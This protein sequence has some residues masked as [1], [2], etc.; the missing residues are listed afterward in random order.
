[1]QIGGYAQ[2][3]ASIVDGV[4]YVGYTDG[5]AALGTP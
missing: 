4:L 3:G 5:I 1:V 2:S